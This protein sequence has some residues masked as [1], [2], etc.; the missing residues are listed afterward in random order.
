MVKTL[1]KIVI[2]GN[3]NFIKNIH[4]IPTP[5]ITLNGERLTAFPVSLR[6]RQKYLL[7]PL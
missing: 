7:L 3:F 5:N 2:E 4:K 6:K 1:R